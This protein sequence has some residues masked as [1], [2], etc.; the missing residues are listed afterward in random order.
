M[1][2]IWL[3]AVLVGCTEPGTVRT[4]PPRTGVPTGVPG[5][6]SP[7]VGL[8]TETGSGAPAG[9]PTSNGCPPHMAWIDG[10]SGPYCIDRYEAGLDGWSPYEVPASG[11]VATVAPGQ[12]PQGYISGE[13]AADACDLAGKR[14]CTVDEWLRACQGPTGTTFPYGDVED[15]GACNTSYDGHPVVDLFGA[16]TD[17]SP[18]QMND[19]RIN[20]QPDTV[21]PGGASPDCVSVEGVFDLHG[22]LH[23]WV[24]DPGGLFKGGFYADAAINGPGCLYSTTAHTP[25][26]H[27]YSTG[28]RCCADP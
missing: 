21:D 20:Q 17:W 16:E 10:P 28:F 18:T 8:P 13:V 15:P 22:N 9:E 24:D 1:R 4:A 12:V 27:D 11:E 2:A 3:L 7:G 23:E 19:P 26:Y 25:P 5:A 6:G 14:L